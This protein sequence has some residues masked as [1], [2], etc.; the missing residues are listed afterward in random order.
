MSRVE[1][2]GNATLYL[3]DCREILP[4]LGKIAAVVTD[5]PYGISYTTPTGIGGGAARKNPLAKP[6]PSLPRRTYGPIVGDSQPFDPSPW[7][8]FPEV[9]LWGANH[10][11]N[12][13]PTSAG[14][15][16][17]DKRD[18]M[19]PNNN[20]DC[21]IAWDK[22]GG[23]AR[24]FRYLWNGM[25]QAGEKGPRVHPAQKPIALMKWCIDRTRGQTI[26]D[27][28]MGS[29]STGVAAVSL[30]RKFIGIEIEPKYFGI[31]YERIRLAVHQPDM[32]SAATA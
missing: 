25:C 22:N 26:L 18:G 20:S 11:A 13:L 6:A 9:I 23:S 19:K 2:I 27:P 30:G 32:F 1:T 31:A 15:L 28:F 10:Y 4:T 12:K 17:W 5:P 24:I 29:G 8:K 3:G 7:L 21:E 14:W 16:I